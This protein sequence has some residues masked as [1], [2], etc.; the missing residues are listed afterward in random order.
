MARSRPTLFVG[1][2]SQGLK[3]A[4]AMQVLLDHSCEVTIWVSDQ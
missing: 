1:S 3:A 2:S 4:K